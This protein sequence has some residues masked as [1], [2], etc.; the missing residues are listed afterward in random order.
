MSLIEA[1]DALLA[2]VPDDSPIPSGSK[3]WRRF[4]VLDRAVWVEAA[5]LG[6]EGKL[7]EKTADECVGFT[8]LPGCTYVYGDFI[9]MGL[10]R[11]TNHLLALRALAEAGGVSEAKGKSSAMPAGTPG[12]SLDEQ[13]LAVRVRRTA[14]GVIPWRIVAIAGGDA[15]RGLCS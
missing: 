12:M 3:Q 15:Q 6:Y 7:P 11:W 10:E 14:F 8:N 13:A 5:R 4:D 9:P 2:H 1:I